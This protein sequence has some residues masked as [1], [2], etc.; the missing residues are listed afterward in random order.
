MS[1]WVDIWVQLRR[2]ENENKHSKHTK[3]LYSLVKYLGKNPFPLAPEM[4]HASSCKKGLI[5]LLHDLHRNKE[6]E[7][8]W[9]KRCSERCLSGKW[10]MRHSSGCE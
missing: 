3:V 6:C 2:C 7:F 10:T 4:D 8:Y 1:L 5:V 9:R